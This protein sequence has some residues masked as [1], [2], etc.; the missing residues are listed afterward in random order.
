MRTSL[1][2]TIAGLLVL[3]A[4]PTACKDG[5]VQ[6]IQGKDDAGTD[7]GDSGAP[8]FGDRQPDETVTVA[9]IGSRVEIARDEFGVPHIFASTIEDA[10]FAQGYM[11]AR[12]RFFQLDLLRHLVEGRL[13]EYFGD[14]TFNT[15]VQNRSNMM[16]TDGQ[17]VFEAMAE[18]VG[19][20]EKSVLEAYAAGV[21][22]YIAALKAGEV[23]IPAGYQNNLLARWKPELVP[24]WRTADTLAIG[25]LQEQ[26]LSDTTAADIARGKAKAGLPADL[27]ADLVRYAPPDPIAVLPEFYE[28]EYF[29]KKSGCTTVSGCTPSLSS[30]KSATSALYRGLDLERASRQI[31]SGDPFGMDH[32]PEG[33]EGSNNWVVSGEHTSTGNAL[34]LND[35]HLRFYNPP[36]FYHSHMDTRHYGG[37][38]DTAASIIG[39]SFPGIPGVLIGHNEHVAWGATTVGY[40]VSDVYVETLN[41]AGD[42]T[43]FNGS[44]VPLVKVTQSIG[45]IGDAGTSLRDQVFEIVPHH[46]VIIPDS[47]ANGKAMTRKWTGHSPKSSVGA[48]LDR[49]HAR[50]VDDFMETMSRFY[51]GA[52]NWNGADVYGNTGYMPGASVPIRANVSGACDPTIPMD[53]SGGCEWTGTIPL[54]EL[55]R[56]KNRPKGYVVTANNDLTGTLADDDP[57]NDPQYL[58]SSNA[59]GF[60]ARIIT[61]RVE[62]LM[63]AGK[64]TK[65]QLV[66]LQ[67]NTTSLMAKRLMP[68]LLAARDAEP[69]LVTSLGISDALSRLSAWDFTNPSGVDADYRTDGGPSAEEIS[70]SIA[71]AIFNTF[72]PRFLK[73]AFGDEEA[74]Y[75]ATFS[76]LPAA[77]YLLENPTGSRTGLGAFDDLTTTGVVETPNQLILKALAD[78]VKFL[79]TTLGAD[80]K[81]WR[82]GAI[83]QE[84]VQDL[85]GEFG[86]SFRTLGPFPR[87]GSNSTV[88][89]AGTGM[90]TDN[91]HFFAGPQMRFVAEVGKDGIVARSSLPGGQIDDPD[92]KHYQDLL[93]PYLRNESF[94]YYF[95]AE[96]VV[97][98]TEELIVLVP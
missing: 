33:V 51:A 36:L 82:W 35:P 70:A 21:N 91:F 39:I 80:P 31:R 64:I 68:F 50:N 44:Y 81:E 37:A 54:N 58:H 94:P 12:D 95:K 47:K 86:V 97:A 32:M 89:V 43:L 27:F 77:L 73:A 76:E 83:H 11:H 60:R 17:P 88:D 92:D 75:A 62:E 4:A 65:E 85:F 71:A 23:K 84:E 2:R 38:A 56:V 25:R 15:D 55:P 8:L 61:D 90:A 1:S 74:Q 78:A 29:G 13:S 59:D 87:G 63:K 72:Q 30:T 79:S 96:D 48:L 19:G 53:G 57:R 5:D 40:D 46:G 52:Q 67:A 98:H 16:T 45:V 34:V 7:A 41:T 24:E 18:G 42:A 6:V 66:T 22:V 49:T 20:T 69:D 26:N 93:P 9:G 3:L 10:S 28:S 14:L